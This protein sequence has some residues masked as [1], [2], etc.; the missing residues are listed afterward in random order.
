MHELKTVRVYDV[1]PQTIGRRILVDRLWPRGL[2]KEPLEPFIWAKDMAPSTNLRK[3]FNHDAKRFEDFS[4][5]YTKELDENP[6][7]Y[8]FVN[9]INEILKTEDVLLLFAAKDENIN[10]AIVLKKWLCGKIDKKTH[11]Q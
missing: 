4:A 2:R 1:N 6:N 11:E 7:G 10:H 9:A 5:G 3:R 8:E